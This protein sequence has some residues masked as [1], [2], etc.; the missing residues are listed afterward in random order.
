[1]IFMKN[2]NVGANDDEKSSMD[3][4]NLMTNYM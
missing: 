4:E 2:S 3:V 1:M